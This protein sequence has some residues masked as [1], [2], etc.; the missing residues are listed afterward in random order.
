MEG[1]MDRLKMENLVMV[2]MLV[3]LISFLGEGCVTIQVKDDTAIDG[4]TEIIAR[5]IAVNVAAKEPDKIQYLREKCDEILAAD[6]EKSYPLIQTAIRYAAEKY[7][8]DSLLYDDVLSLLKL[9]GVT[10]DVPDINLD[11]GEL[12]TLRN[13]IAVFRKTLR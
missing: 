5:R 3:C 8:G 9:F 4:V 10:P 1:M 11:M 12:R 6:V 7:T 2:L 13:A